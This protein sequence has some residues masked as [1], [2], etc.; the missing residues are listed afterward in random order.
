[1]IPCGEARQ[2]GGP[3]CTRKWPP[4]PSTRQN[5]PLR[6]LAKILY[7]SLLIYPAPRHYSLAR[8]TP[9]KPTRNTTHQ[10]SLDFW[11]L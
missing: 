4:A 3:F 8:S 5:L 11:L 7:S 2:K 10:R 6:G 9:D 1:M